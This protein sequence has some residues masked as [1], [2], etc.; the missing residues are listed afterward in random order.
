[1][2]VCHVFHVMTNHYILHRNWVFYSSSSVRVLNMCSSSNSIRLHCTFCTSLLIKS[3]F[4]T[5]P[6]VNHVFSGSKDSSYAFLSY[7]SRILYTFGVCCAKDCSTTEIMCVICC[8]RFHRSCCYCN[9]FGIALLSLY[10]HVSTVLF[11]RC[12]GEV[13]VMQ[14]VCIWMRESDCSSVTWYQ[15]RNHNNLLRFCVFQHLDC[16][17][18]LTCRCIVALKLLFFH[19]GCCCHRR[20]RLGLGRIC[21]HWFQSCVKRFPISLLCSWSFEIFFSALLVIKRNKKQQVEGW[22]EKKS[23]NAKN[24]NWSDFH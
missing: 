3:T 6:G 20:R 15:F 17:P 8:C 19:I 4:L 22:M 23:K 12:G 13:S 21:A 24:I 10:H 5:D 18:Y 1:M 9:L 2:C 11:W 7:L 14:C 16:S